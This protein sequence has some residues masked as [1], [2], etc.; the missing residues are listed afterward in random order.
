[1]DSNSWISTLFHPQSIEPFCFDDVRIHGDCLRGRPCNCGL[2]T[3]LYSYQWLLSIV[4]WVY[5]QHPTTSSLITLGSGMILVSG[6]DTLFYTF[7][8]TSKDGLNI[9]GLLVFSI[10]FGIILGN[11]GEEGKPLKDFFNCLSEASMK[12]VNLVIWLVISELL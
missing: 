5:D 7:T 3:T 1:M 12:M 4:T 11:M 9:L 2:I 6:N 8:V 10:A